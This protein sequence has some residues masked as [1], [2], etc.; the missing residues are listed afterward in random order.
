MKFIGLCG[1]AAERGW[2]GKGQKPNSALFRLTPVDD[3]AGAQ[4]IAD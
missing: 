4:P 1:R 2:F 3:L